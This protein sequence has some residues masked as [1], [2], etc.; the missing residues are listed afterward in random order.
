MKMRNKALW[1]I[2][3]AR[4]LTAHQKAFL[5]V[6]ESRGECSTKMTKNAQ[7]MGLGKDSYY[8][9]R[10]PLI[11]WGIIEERRRFEDSTVYTVNL[12]ALLSHSA[13]HEADSHS[14]SAKDDSHS[15]KDSSL[16]AKDDS[17]ETETK[18]NIKKNTKKTKKKNSASVADA[19][20][21]ATSE[22]QGLKDDH[23]SES[24][25]SEPSLPTVPVDDSTSHESSTFEPTINE[26]DL[27]EPAEPAR[28]ANIS[29][30]QL[31][32]AAEMLGA[33]TIDKQRRN[34]YAIPENRDVIV[35]R[36]GKP[37][38]RHLPTAEAR[39]EAALDAILGEQRA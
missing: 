39:C 22:I 19:P 29:R 8:R 25:I 2:R 16:Y 34:L 28:P 1:A 36:A 17:H 27:G 30:G 20:E 23:T 38:F 12:E 4:G 24:L 33:K 13:K 10:N 11:E 31:K 14:H 18:K 7:D 6:V 21:A 37:E 26:G 32:A 35:L 5:F 3:D 9:A 15:A